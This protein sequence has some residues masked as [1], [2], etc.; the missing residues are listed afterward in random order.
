MNTENLDQKNVT[1]QSNQSE[2]Q[3]IFTSQHKILT[4]TG[5]KKTLSNEGLNTSEFITSVKSHL[6]ELKKMGH[7]NPIAIGSIP[8]DITQKTEFFIPN[9]SVYSDNFDSSSENSESNA[10]KLI[11]LSQVTGEQHFKGA[12]NKALSLSENT[13]LDKVVLSRA[14]DVQTSETLNAQSM[15]RV[16]YQQN[17]SAYVFSIP[18]SNG[19]ILVGASPELLVKKQGNQVS[20]NPLAGS[21]KRTAIT[22]Q[23]EQLSEELWSCTKDR[24]EHK[25]VAEAVY[26]N[27]KPFCDQLNNPKAPSIIET[28]AMIHLSTKIDGTLTSENTSALDLAYALHPTPA[29]CGTPAHLAKATIQH[30]EGYER[31]QFCGAVGWMDADGNGEWVVT[32]RCGVIQQN[33][34]RLYAG[35]GIVQGSDPAAEFN[36]TEAKLNTMLTALGFNAANEPQQSTQAMAL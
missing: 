30:L 8:F 32:I 34:I 21:R 19:S 15:A 36:E 25:L 29:I 14:I 33:S 17:P 18:Q 20:S 9:N 28:S 35:A 10:T 31:A 7:D 13:Q 1:Q 6:K 3:F 26:Q 27:L 16:L 23:N 11:S 4:A 5:I 22:K 24:F 12:V 2:V